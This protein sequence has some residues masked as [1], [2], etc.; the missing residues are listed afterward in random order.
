MDM[1]LKQ[2]RI[3]FAIS[4]AAFGL[5][6]II[7]AHSK[8]PFLSMIPWVPS[9][10]P[11]G[12]LTGIALL[13]GGISILANLRMRHASML[14]GVLFLL[15][16]IFLQFSRVA[17]SPWDV[18]VRTCAFE[19]LTMCASAWMLADS[20][21][22]AGEDSSR[23]K[24]ALNTVLASG[25]YLF[26]IS[27]IVFGID[28]YLVFNLIV[29][30][31]PHWIPGSGWFWANLTAFALIAAGF[32][33]AVKWLDRWA[34]ALLGL[35]FLIWFLVLHAPRVLSYPRCLDPDEW[36]SAFIALAV[37]GGAWIL[38]RSIPAKSSSKV[39]G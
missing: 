24:P 15:C 33:I 37:C 25:R 5:Q 7:W 30:L 35:M 27:M 22:G 13:L 34:A 23:W 26:A 10:P 39:R 36:S 19:T 21:R 9:Y 17:A 2:G 11:L 3:L 18:G 12:Y 1:L 6:N 16:V 8:D 32:S 38:A 14:L 20:R 4:I 28:H 31:V 29:S